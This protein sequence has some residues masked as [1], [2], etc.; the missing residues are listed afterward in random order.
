MKGKT[1]GETSTRKGPVEQK[2]KDKGVQS[3]YRNQQKKGKAH[4]CSHCKRKGHAEASCRFRPNVR[5]RNCNQLGHVQRVCKNKAETQV[6]ANE[7][8]E[9]AETTEEH[10]FM[11]Q[12]GNLKTVDASLWLLN[13]GAS[14][15]MTPNVKLFVEIDDQYRSKVE[16]GNGVYLQA[17]GKG[18]VPIQTSSCASKSKDKLNLI[19]SDVGGPLSEESLN[20]SRSDNGG[21]YTSQEF[22][23]FLEKEGIFHQLTAPYCPQQ[24]GVSE[25]KNSTVLEMCRCLMF[26]KNM[27]KRFWA[28]AASTAVYLLNIIPTRAK[29]NITPY[30]EW[31]GTTPFVDHLRVFGS[32]CYQHIPEE[33]RDKLQ[34]KAQMGISVSRNVVFDENKSWNWEQ[35][36]A[37]DLNEFINV[38][39]YQHTDS[40]ILVDAETVDEAPVRRVRSIQNIYERCHMAI[41]EPNSYEDAAVHE[42]WVTAIKEKLN[43][44]VKNKTWSLV[45]RPKDR[46]LIGVKWIFK[47]KLNPDGTLNRYKARLVVKG[48]S[49]IL[50]ID[51]QETFAPVARLDTIRL[52][53]ALAAAF[54]WKLFHLDVKSAF[55]N[56]KLDEEI[57]VEQPPGFELCS[58]Q[59]KVFKLHKALYG[60]KQ[61]PCAWYNRINTYLLDQGFLKSPNKATLYVLKHYN[62]APLILSLYVDDLLV[63]RGSEDAIRKFKQ[64]MEKEFYMSDLGDMRLEIKRI[65]RGIH[66]SQHKYVLEM[67]K[68]FQMNEC[69]ATA[70]PLVVNEKLSSQSGYELENPSQYRSLIGCLLYPCATRPDVMFAV[71]YLSR[72]MQKSRSCHFVAAK[73]ILRY[74]KGTT[75]FGLKFTHT[76]TVKLS[77]FSNSDWAGSLDDAKSTSG[78]VFTLGNGTF[79][80]S[81]HKQDTVAQSS[82]EAE[83]VAATS[84]ANHAIWVR[85]AL[86]DLTMPQL[87][88]TDLWLDNKSAIA[89]A[90]NL[91][92]HGKTKHISVKYHALRDAEKKGEICIQYCPEDQLADIMTKAL[93]KPMFEFQRNKLM[94]H[95]AS[96]KGEC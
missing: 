14:N 82:A 50:G 38:S 13:S 30:E 33:Q 34:P 94:V 52:L 93:R 77:G 96:I 18:L 16:I 80:W 87:E 8:V 5:C 66:V 10:L 40:Q 59:G 91:V 28:E 23:Q 62:E 70:S 47:R 9:K 45:D 11:V 75:A 69:K 74:L 81:S 65:D 78:Y 4:I 64:N 76:K 7:P 37:V 68:K 19:H 26:E 21:E 25:R 86:H 1:V 43:M 12:T 44:I 48:Y 31:Y 51:F 6:K 39:N 3:V 42:H 41:T 27:P 67:L 72:F 24:N 61:A 57:Y 84:A 15:H 17:T 73:R 95:Q 92:F 20:G 35:S 83:Y 29:Q 36:Q 89:M 85:K 79:S 2:E 71:S 56:G 58:G 60:L 53:I 46:Q 49:Q 22:S 55:L 88:A 32:L 63:T 90:K 54:Q